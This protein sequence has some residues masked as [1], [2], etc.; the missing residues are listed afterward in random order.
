[1]AL[2]FW[3]LAFGFGL[4]PQLS[5]SHGYG[6]ATIRPLLQLECS[7][8]SPLRDGDAVEV[9]Y[10]KKYPTPGSR[11]FVRGFRTKRRREATIELLPR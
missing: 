11:R 4:W 7:G 5:R 3:L 2:G 8:P 10:A 6:R 1:L 9:A